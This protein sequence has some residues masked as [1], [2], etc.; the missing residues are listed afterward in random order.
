MLPHD[1][2]DIV[3]ESSIE[4]VDL[5]VMQHIQ[6][7]IFTSVIVYHLLLNIQSFSIL[8]ISHSF[9]EPPESDGHLRVDEALLL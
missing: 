8:T 1:V 9:P 7:T 2:G 6:V 3:A 4:F 5:N